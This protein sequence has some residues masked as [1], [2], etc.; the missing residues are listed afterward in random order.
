M[1]DYQPPYPPPSRPDRPPPLNTAPLSTAPPGAAPSWSATSPVPAP[2][3]SWS[4]TV[5]PAPRIQT[6]PPS[7]RI[8]ARRPI[9]GASAVLLPFNDDATINWP[10]FEAHLVHTVHAGLIPAVNMDTGFGAL[11]TPAQ[12][13][14]AL[15]IAASNA[16]NG[17]IAGAHVTDAPGALFAFD[18]YR[19]ELARITQA[20]GTPIIFPSYGLARISDDELVAAHAAFGRD[21]DAFLAFEL[22]TAFHPAGR[23]F[24]LD[25]F[26]ALL[27]I[28]SLRGLKHSSLDRVQEWDRLALRDARRADFLVL[29]GNDLA[30]DMVIYGS[31]YLLGLSTF[32]PEAF[33]ARDAAWAAGDEPRFWALNDVLQYLGRLAFRPPVPGY[34]HDA[35]MFLAQRGWLASDATH[36]SSPTRPDSDRAL[37]ADIATT[38]D[39]LL[40]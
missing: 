4:A 30:I 7:A 39:T 13:A 22:S 6:A 26:A 29:T 40:T 35:A 37:L 1:S 33:A 19:T 25:V 12:R 10:A 15:H 38:L 9:K 23:I 24:S 18:A 3:P 8:V 28:P 5:P 32:S 20:G 16:P 34:R 27:E 21:V 31:D 2:A 36:P 11:L 17:F 14:Y